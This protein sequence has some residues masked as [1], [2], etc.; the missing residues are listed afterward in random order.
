MAKLLGGSQIYGNATV[1]S[2]LV[3]SGNADLSG[4]N[5]TIGTGNTAVTSIVITNR[6]T[7]YTSNP[8]IT[9][10]SPTTLYG[11][12]ATA[13]ANLGVYGTPTISNG[14][15]G[16]AVNNVLTMV[17]T[18]NAVS[19]ATFTVTS[20]SSGVITGVSVTTPGTY[21][22]SNTTS[23]IT[24]TGG[25][26]TGATLTVAYG[27]NPPTVTYAG[28]G[29]VERPTVT[30]TGGGGTGATAY[31]TVGGPGN[32]FVLG[33]T[34]SISTPGGEAV[35]ITDVVGAN[36]YVSISPG[37]AGVSSPGI[38][39]GG[40]GEAFDI[41]SNSNSI[42]FSTG[43]AK[44]NNIQAVVYPTNNAVNYVQ[45]TGAA[46]GGGPVVGVAGTDTNIDLNL[47][48]KGLGN[49][50][51]SG[52]LV[53]GG[54][55][56][57]GTGN[58]QVSGIVISNAGNVTINSGTANG[59]AYLNG[60]NVLTT[61]SALV[62]DGTNLGVGV[63]PSAWGGSYSGKTIQ[64][65]TTGAISSPN[66]GSL[67]LFY[68]AYYNGT[69]YIYSTNDWA[70]R[71]SVEGNQ[72]VWRNAAS[73]TAGNAIT[74]TQAMTL[75]TNGALVLQG[76]NTSASGV[77]IAFPATQSASSDAN[78]LDDYEEGTWTPVLSDGTTSVASY[79][80]QFGTYTKIGDMVWVNCTISVNNK[81]SISGTEMRVTGLPFA[82]YSS[83]STYESYELAAKIF[84][85]PTGTA[86]IGEIDA[87]S[88]NNTWIIP[89]SY[90]ANAQ[91]FVAASAVSGGSQFFFTGCYRTTT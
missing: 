7:G 2:Y 57:I 3:V 47:G 48:G 74:F 10:S 19:N 84:P 54:N 67:N 9:V 15:T 51:T 56:T 26:G 42:R 91:N 77:G 89:Y 23:P 62:F 30:I 75:N 58:T 39:T 88:P 41:F 20:V 24:V 36:R 60:S 1:N 4:G 63:T 59:V 35:R 70:Q 5:V 76:G 25:T 22:S 55:F 50:K 6:G 27:V 65:G 11:G 46:T 66:N 17:G 49:V 12:T 82:A 83:N 90:N 33:N 37:Q 13:N 69:N 28:T 86:G 44:A 78:T 31:A 43:G 81:G 64:I 45:V 8:T 85:I 68:N 32:I 52:N 61:G 53:V 40:G 72:F 34:L 73:G 21:F 18:A 16:Y 38:G 29:Y 79:Y 14:G 80:Y 87:S 71:F